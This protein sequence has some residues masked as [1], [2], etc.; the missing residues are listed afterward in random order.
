M[1]KQLSL[2]FAVL[3]VAACAVAQLSI[4]LSHPPSDDSPKRTGNSNQRVLTGVVMDKSDQPIPNAVVYL[5]NEKTLNVRSY[6]AQ[7]DGTYR[8]PQLENNVDYEVYAEIDGKRSDTKT[9]SQFDNRTAPH[10][11]L[12]INLN[13]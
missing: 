11:N 10:V 12:R 7:K 3:V 8:F 4:P 13:K 2:L 5:K 6:F 9:V 1:K